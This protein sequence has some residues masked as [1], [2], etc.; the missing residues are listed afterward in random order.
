MKEEVG[1]NEKEEESS[2]DSSQNDSLTPQADDVEN[3]TGRANSFEYF[4]GKSSFPQ[5][6]D[7]KNEKLNLNK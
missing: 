7:S 3:A 1:Q 2:S 4:P 5:C 6:K